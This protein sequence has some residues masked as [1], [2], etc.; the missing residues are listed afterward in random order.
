MLQKGST[1]M[2][3][4]HK[5]VCNKVSKASSFLCFCIL[6]VVKMAVVNRWSDAISHYIILELQLFPHRKFEK[7]TQEFFVREGNEVNI[8]GEK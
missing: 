5:Y 1:F 3:I 8:L 2:E 4:K 6:H 7:N